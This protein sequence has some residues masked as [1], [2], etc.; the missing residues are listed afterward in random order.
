MSQAYH[1]SCFCGAV[2]IEASGEPVAMGFCHCSSCRSWT[3]SVVGA[4]TMWP[5]ETI[6]VTAGAKHLTT[7]LKTPDTV[8]H[9]QSC[10]LCGGNVM[11]HHPTFGLYDVCASTLPGLKFVPTFHVNYAET[12]FPIQDGL[13]KYKGFP[14]DFG[15]TGEELPE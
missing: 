3:G 2:R 13:P 1:G 10:R 7:F 15:G 6:K 14:E 12:V 4:S 11:I 8:S 5:I 9:R